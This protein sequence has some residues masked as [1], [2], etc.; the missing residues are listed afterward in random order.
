M[1]LAVYGRENTSVLLDWVNASF[2]GVRTGLGSPATYSTTAFP[3]PPYTG[4]LV[5]YRPEASTNTLTLFWQTPSLQGH[6]QNAVSKFLIRYLGHE[7]EGSLL[8]YLKGRGMATALR[9]GI[10]VAADSFYLFR[11]QATL[12]ESGLG[13]VSEVIQAVFHYTYLLANLTEEEFEEKWSDYVTVSGVT[14]DYAEN[15]SPNDYAL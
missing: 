12:T 3:G 10:E 9:A 14:F 13:V 4:R 8:A 6:S 11:I 5:H 7:G 2:A 15:Q 1:N